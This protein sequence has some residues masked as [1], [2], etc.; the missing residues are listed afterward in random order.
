MF[1]YINL[2]KIS[3]YDTYNNFKKNWTNIHPE[4]NIK[5]EERIDKVLDSGSFSF[6]SASIISAIDPFTLILF[7]SEEI[8]KENIDDIES[9]I[10]HKFFVTSQLSKERTLNN[11]YIYKHTCELYELTK[12][13][14]KYL[15]GAKALSNIDDLDNYNENKYRIEEICNVVVSKYHNYID[16]IDT[17]AFNV[18]NTNNFKLSRE[19]S[20]GDGTTLFDALYEISSTEGAI[21]RVINVTFEDIT[22]ISV[23][24]DLINDIENNKDIKIINEFSDFKD[25]ISVDDYCDA[26]ESVFTNVVDRDT[27]S[28]CYVSMRSEDDFIYKDN[29]CLLLPENVET[30]EELEIQTTAKHFYCPCFFIAE[31]YFFTTTLDGYN[32]LSEFHCPNATQEYD[33]VPYDLSVFTN[34]IEGQTFNKYLKTEGIE[35]FNKCV[36][37]IIETYKNLDIE[38]SASKVF[39]Y[40]LGYSSKTNKNSGVIFFLV[41]DGA[42]FES[43][44]LYPNSIYING[45]DYFQFSDNVTSFM[46][47]NNI[48]LNKTQYNLLSEREQ[49]LYLYYESGSNYVKGFYNTAKTDFW[50]TLIGQNVGPALNGIG[51]EMTHQFYNV[52]KVI[53]EKDNTITTTDGTEGYAYFAT[54]AT[55]YYKGFAKGD[56]ITGIDIFTTYRVTYFPKTQLLTHIEKNQNKANNQFTKSYAVSSSTIDYNKLSKQMQIEVNRIGLHYKYLTSLNELNIGDLTKYGYCFYKI[57]IMFTKE[58]K[59][60]YTYGFYPNAHVVAQAIGVDSQYEATKGYNTGIIDRYLYFKLNDDTLR[61]ELKK[62]SKKAY[63]MQLTYNNGKKDIDLALQLTKLIQGDKVYLIGKTQDNFC[64]AKQSIDAKLIFDISNIFNG[65]YN[66]N[67]QVPYAN[68]NTQY[69]ESYKIKIGSQNIFS[70]TTLDNY[71]LITID[72]IKIDLGEIK[73]FKDPREH[74]IFTFEI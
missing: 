16:N 47:L 33:R 14:E 55:D 20:F 32:T 50:N 4:G 72:N 39:W 65:I 62:N 51:N 19:Y 22:T 21:P 59:K 8:T 43:T 57:T 9:L 56:N 40:K 38:Y 69:Q 34:L 30:I 68:T 15:L 36:N 2:T 64:F 13:L 35:I 18:T 58:N 1:Y 63:L 25:E 42:K 6:H 12:I 37:T 49:P 53:E 48:L 28:T 73:I 46:S 66:I 23:S 11:T 74:L 44:A 17:L 26:F 24:F 70:T 29:A 52:D 54:L 3:K 31:K 7:T 27:P 10:V 5:I 41:S 71:P 60:L 67:N 61:T 45:D